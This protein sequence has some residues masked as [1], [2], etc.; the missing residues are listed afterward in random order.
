[1]LLLAAILLGLAL[2]R[3]LGGSWSNLGNLQF[4]HG[5]LILV[6]LALQ[7]AAF[8]RAGPLG[9][10]APAAHLLSYVL[11]LAGIALNWRYM[12]LRLLGLGTLLNLAVIACNG[13]YMPAMPEAL[14]GAGQADLLARLQ[15][16]GVLG[17]TTLMTDTT[18]LP[19]L[20]DIFYVPSF[21][22]MA[23]VF[24]VGDV[25]IALGALLLVVQTMRGH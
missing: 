4:R 25:L 14:I 24:S 10:L 8:S 6:A 15:A 13:G 21:V 5:W 12:G 7:L 19:W 11:L 3:L 18:C 1:M 17:N 20:G 16:D 22:P 2:G 23:L 9:E